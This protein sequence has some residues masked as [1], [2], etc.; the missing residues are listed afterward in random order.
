M[1]RIFLY[2]ALFFFVAVP[3][4]ANDLP[5]TLI[6]DEMAEFRHP[7]PMHLD[8]NVPRRAILANS[9]PIDSIVG[10]DLYEKHVTKTEYEYDEAGHTIAETQYKWTNDVM[11]GVSRYWKKYTGSTATTTVNYKWDATNAV[12]VGKDSTQLLFDANGRQTAQEV[13][14]WDNDNW[15]Y[16]S[17]YEYEYNSAGKQ[18]LSQYS[19]WSA[20][21]QDLVYSNKWVWVYGEN[22]NT[23]E[24]YWLYNNGWVG[25]SKKVN[26]YDAKGN[27]TLSEVYSG[28]ENNAWKGKSRTASVFDANNKEIEKYTYK[29]T[30]TGWANNYWY[31]KQYDGT[32][33]IDEAT[34]SWKDENWVGSS[35]TSRTYSGSKISD[36]IVWKW[37]ETDW[38][39]KSRIETEYTS[40][41]IAKQINSTWDG[42]DWVKV[43]KVENTYEAGKISV[44]L[45]SGWNGSDWQ[46]SLRTSHAY[47]GIYDTLVVNTKFHDGNWSAV[48][49][50]LRNI[51]Y[52]TVA[53]KQQ[54]TEDCTKKW[55]SKNGIWKGVDSLSNKYDA[56]GNVIL[57][58]TYSYSGMAWVNKTE[59]EY[60]YK[61]NNGSLKTLESYKSWNA[62][63]QTWSSTVNSKY[64][65]DYDDTNRKVMTAIYIWNTSHGDQG[66]WEGSSRKRDVYDN[67]LKVTS[68][69]DKWNSTAWAWTGMF[70]SDYTYT[71][72]GKEQ[73]TVT[74]RYN[75]EQGIYIN[76][77]RSVN[78]GSL[79]ETYSWNTT[80]DDW[81]QKTYSE[82]VYDTDAAGKLRYVLSET[83]TDCELATSNLKHY[84]YRC[85]PK[86][87][88]ITFVNWND[89]TL[90]T[91]TVEEG[92]QPIYPTDVAQPLRTEDVNFTYSFNGWSPEIET[93]TGP[94]TYVAQFTATPK[95]PTGMDAILE[96]SNPQTFK[97]I[98]NGQLFILRNGEIYNVQGIRVK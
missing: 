35:R 30:S 5:D 94:A 51:I 20:V 65:Y 27:K 26:E 31:S 44:N 96:S 61:N 75:Q 10:T 60:A 88:T 6:L 40:N 68:Y 38:E 98:K 73:E 67:N 21:A 33:V 66:D 49:S 41:N 45:T 90:A 17:L 19:V 74:A 57:V 77:S 34:Y 53:G 52:A 2:I 42:T 25:S 58:N 15:R 91:I 39:H 83:Y 32:K 81:C 84:Y 7:K 47:K 11:T 23:I 18:T 97:L 3:T 89:T 13:F 86:K 8:L 55:E 59:R 82:T 63:K 92:N 36:E 43:S 1:R 70:R 4:F 48:D 12:W 56:A 85:D 46:D 76:E 72:S 16:K 24:E 64:E 50:T 62:T 78:L 95:V 28:W 22:G 79:T 9:C 80:L 29:W 69:S 37:N 93:V 71:S 14:A 54:I 87:Y